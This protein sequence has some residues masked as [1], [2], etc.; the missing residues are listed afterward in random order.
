MVNFPPQSFPLQIV[1]LFVFGTLHIKHASLTNVGDFHA[2]H[3]GF[4]HS[5]FYSFWLLIYPLKWNQAS[6]VKHRLSDTQTSSCEKKKRHVLPIKELPFNWQPTEMKHGSETVLD[7]LTDVGS[8][9]C[10]GSRGQ[11]IIY[12]FHSLHMS[13]LEVK[14]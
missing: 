14:S 1:P 9:Q 7:D 13:N 12:S 8:V 4:Q 3:V 11:H 5:I 10:S 6:S 2:V